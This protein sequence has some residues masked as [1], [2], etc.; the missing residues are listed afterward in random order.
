MEF[1]NV[2]STSRHGFV[3]NVGT[4]AGFTRARTC[5]TAGE[6]AGPADR[7]DHLSADRRA[8]SVLLLPSEEVGRLRPE[9]PKPRRPAAGASVA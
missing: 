9:A 8:D 4:E 5:T 6:Q 7:D 2:H 1:F 3:R